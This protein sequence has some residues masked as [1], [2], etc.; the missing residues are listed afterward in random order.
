MVTFLINIVKAI[1]FIMDNGSALE[2]E[3][4]S[5]LFEE[6]RGNEFFLNEL[7]AIQNDDGGFP[8]ALR[9]GFLSSVGFTI[10]SIF[11]YYE[12]NEI[13]SKP[14]KRAIEFLLNIQKDDGCW[15]E[16]S[17]I[18]QYDP[19][20]IIHPDN[21]KA[22]VHLTA[23]A[24]FCLLMSGEEYKNKLEKTCTFLEQQTNEDGTVDGFY[25]TSFL[26]AAFLSL[27]YDKRH[28]T[29]KKIIHYLEENF[30]ILYS[31]TEISDMCYFLTVAG[32]SLE[33]KIIE[34]CMETLS[35]A[36]KA[37]GRIASG[38]DK[39]EDIHATINTLKA[40]AILNKN[41]KVK[42]V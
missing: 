10:I 42:N 5:C 16:S 36:Q 17:K 4:I 37:D 8:Y 12:M 13:F 15:E 41:K 26:T 29:V 6:R 3:V 19:P 9:P 31:I 21:H 34:K 30:D 11:Q 20:E 39:E 35:S 38:V 24:G 23:L 25:E 2:Q 33:D 27:F 28:P 22:K 40:V 14:V 32:F 18:C 7:N 1:K